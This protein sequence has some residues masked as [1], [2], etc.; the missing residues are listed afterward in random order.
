MKSS[1]QNSDLAFHFQDFQNSASAIDGSE[2]ARNSGGTMQ[3]EQKIKVIPKQI[4]A[5]R[6]RNVYQTAKNTQ[7]RKQYALSD[8]KVKDSIKISVTKTH[9]DHKMK[10]LNI[11]DISKGTNNEEEKGPE[12]IRN[13]S[14]NSTEEF[15][16]NRGLEVKIRKEMPKDFED[17]SP[18]RYQDSNRELQ[19]IDLEQNRTLRLT[20][21][22]AFEYM[23]NVCK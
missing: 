7:E 19:Q 16:P 11:A 12:T 2:Y 20:N 22:S 23:N 18:T 6:G 17:K 8:P 1:Y 5:V 10:N 21:Y 14:I 9:N 13:P 3:I 15:Q 4:G